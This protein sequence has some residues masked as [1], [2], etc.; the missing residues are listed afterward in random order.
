MAHWNKHID[1]SK[2]QKLHKDEFTFEKINYWNKYFDQPFDGIITIGENRYFFEMS[3]EFDSGNTY[4]VYDGL[5]EEPIYY[6]SIY[7]H[8]SEVTDNDHWIDEDEEGEYTVRSWEKSQNIITSE[9]IQ[10]FQ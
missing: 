6:F 3:H 9:L 7:I 1:F 4:V 10:S 8:E 2:L 5:N